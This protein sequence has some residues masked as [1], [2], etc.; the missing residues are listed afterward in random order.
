MAEAVC[1]HTPC[2]ILCLVNLY[3]LRLRRREW[4]CHDTCTRLNAFA[5]Q[6][7]LTENKYHFRFVPKRSRVLDNIKFEFS[8]YNGLACG[9]ILWE[10]FLFLFLFLARLAGKCVNDVTWLQH[11]D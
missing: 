9:S 5:H 1:C 8:I 10:L 2:I 7:P 6:Q 11:S 4:I 3:V